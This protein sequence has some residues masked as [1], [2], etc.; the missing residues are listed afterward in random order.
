MPLSFRFYL[1]KRGR[2]TNTFIASTLNFVNVKRNLSEDYLS[3]SGNQRFLKNSN[4]FKSII[5]KSDMIETDPVL[6]FLYFPYI[7]IQGFSMLY[8]KYPGFTLFVAK[9]VFL[10]G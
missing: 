4:F 8:N 9:K 10:G 7:Q 2:F 3:V 6:I 5:K 1:I